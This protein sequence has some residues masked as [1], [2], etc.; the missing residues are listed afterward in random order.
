MKNNDKMIVPKLRF[1]E[2]VLNPAW[3]VYKLGNL[4]KPVTKKTNGE[5]YTLMSVTSGEGLVSQLEKFGRE[6]A[7]NSYKNYYVIQENDFAY[8]KSATKLYS[9][10]YIAMLQGQENAALPNSIFTC[11]RFTNKNVCVKYFDHLFHSNY[12]GKWL[13]QYITVGAR[14]NG[15]LAVDNKHLWSMPIA[16]P[17]EKEEQHKIADCL[18]SLDEL[19]TAESKK[20]EQ[21]Q[22]HKKG[23]MQ[24][25]FP[26][27]GKTMP[28]WRFPEFRGS[29]EWVVV[30]INDVGEIITGK[31]PSTNDSSLWNGDIQFVTPTDIT[32]EKYQITT[33]RTIAH[34]NKMKILPIGTVMFTCIASIGKMSISTKL[35]ITNQQINSIIPYANYDNS[36]IYYVLSSMLN[37]IRELAGKQAVPIINKTLFSSIEIKIP[38]TFEEQQKIANCLSSV[39]WLISEQTKKI[40]ELKEHKKGLTQGLFPSFEEVK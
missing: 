40:N 11:F 4:T 7:G 36:F 9:E 22:S 19:I 18:T 15:A 33:S 26:A 39:D 24:K 14:A 13:K 8:N 38:N 35:C 16:L 25:L 1:K 31:T 20:L 27:E 32:E 17:T 12:H 6:I 29:T 21:L 5:S 34:I 3:K 10:G 2:F 30:E 23:L 28:E 37:S